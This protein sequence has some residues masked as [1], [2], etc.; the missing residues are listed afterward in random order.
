MRFSW[1]ASF[2][3]MIACNFP[4]PW[5]STRWRRSL[6]K[7]ARFQQVLQ[8]CVERDKTMECAENIMQIQ[9]SATTPLGSRALGAVGS[10]SKGV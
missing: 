5:R 7:S 3:S 1:G 8:I 6:V 2:E 9:L 4:V 10:K